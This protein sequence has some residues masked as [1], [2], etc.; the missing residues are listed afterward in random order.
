MNRVPKIKLRI[1]ILGMALT[2][3]GCGKS[4]ELVQAPVVGIMQGIRIPILI[5]TNGEGK[6]RIEYQNVDEENGAFSEWYSLSGLNDFSASLTLDNISHGATYKYRIQFENE[7]YSQWFQFK[8]FPAANKPGKFSFIFS[9]CM[10]EKYMGFNI[11]EKI[12]QRSPTFVALLGDQMYGDYDGD[13]NK[14]EDYLEN[15][16]LRE[17]MT[18]EG[19]II[20]SDKSVLRAFRS[21]YSRVFDGNFQKMVR[22]IP[23]MATWDD[24]DYGKDN[25]DG[26][27]PYKEEAKRVFKENYPAYPFEVEDGGI[28]YKFTIADVDVF[29]LDT[30]WYRS[31]MEDEDGKDKK[32]LGDAQ[33]SWLLAGL[34]ESQSACKIVFSSVSLNDYGGDTSSGRTGYDSWMG[35]KFE[36]NKILSF[37]KKNQIQGV[38]VFSGD[39]HYPSAHILNSQTPLQ[40]VSHSEEKVEYSIQDMGSAVFDFSASPLN[41]KKA[42]GHPLILKNQENPDFSFEIFRPDWAIPKDTPKDAPLVI[43]SVF[44]FAEIDTER[45]PIKV[46]VTFYEL[47][48]E[49][50]EMVEIYGVEVTF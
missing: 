39:Q 17:K 13:L 41:Y 46:L 22:N 2:L 20:L 30:R 15:A 21:K 14:L 28:Y 50:S 7:D 12:A 3:L 23:L 9:A 26:A 4:N 33:L 1:F 42:S 19:E 25:S 47:N 5:K 36:R 18:K 40:A 16:S 49:I 45:S 37:I 35:Y 34:K 38:L 6:V 29:V 43:G 32:M 27:Y 31:P 48:P 44:G 10:R 8:S 24:H 11:F